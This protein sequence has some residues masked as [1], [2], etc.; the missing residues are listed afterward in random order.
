V[1]EIILSFKN[2]AT[3]K[4]MLARLATVLREASVPVSNMSNLGLNFDINFIIKNESVLFDFRADIARMCKL[5]SSGDPG[6][7]HLPQ[8]EY[9]QHIYEARKLLNVYKDESIYTE[10]D[11][12]QVRF[13]NMARSLLTYTG[14]QAIWMPEKDLTFRH[15]FQEQGIFNYTAMGSISCVKRGVRFTYYRVAKSANNV[16]VKMLKKCRAAQGPKAHYDREFTFSFVR[17]PL[18]RFISGY[19]EIEF[20]KKLHTMKRSILG[21][22]LRR[23]RL[24][25]DKDRR[26]VS[27]HPSFYGSEYTRHPSGTTSRA[28]T[29]IQDFVGGRILDGSTSTR[30]EY[31]VFLQYAFLY[32]SLPIDYIGYTG[33]INRDIDRMRII[34]HPANE[35]EDTHVASNAQ[36]QNNER[37]AMSTLLKDSPGVKCALVRMLL[38][39]YI[40]FGFPLPLECTKQPAFMRSVE[41]LKC[42]Y[43]MPVNDS[44]LSVPRRVKAGFLSLTKN[45]I[46]S[47]ERK[48][49]RNIFRG[50]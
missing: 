36:S 11:R 23:Q 31:H 4:E 43:T 47:Q 8:Y 1:Q 3:E 21:R 2:E 34:S 20:R 37:T 26:G 19:S 29:F 12:S 49:N 16:V 39:D 44:I 25:R 22:S 6:G 48:R 33:N 10:I 5:P 45:E 41:R 27:D 35:I 28:F 7:R 9:L 13:C 17:D 15:Y 40:C 50:E 14:G 42:P 18:E 46:I 38:L 32:D 24:D 30:E